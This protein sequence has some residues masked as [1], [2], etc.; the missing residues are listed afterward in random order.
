[1]MIESWVNS[2]HEWVS[3]QLILWEMATACFERFPIKPMV[4]PSN[5]L[6]FV[7]TFVTI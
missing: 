1:M 7:Q 3:M 2:L 6:A 4:P 5:T